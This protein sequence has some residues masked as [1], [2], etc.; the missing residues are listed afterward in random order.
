MGAA[1]DTIVVFTSDH[2][3]MF[4]D[5]GLMLKAMMHYQGA[6]RV[7]LTIAG[8]GVIAGRT[9]S[10]APSLDLAQ[11]FL[12]LTGL[13]EFD[14]M[15]GQSLTPILDDPTATVRDHVFVE[16]DMPITEHAPIPHKARTVFTAE[17]RITRFSAGETE[18]YDFRDDPDELNN[19]A[20]TAPD[21]A[22]ARA[23]SDRLTQ[24]LIDYADMARINP[25]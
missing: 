16:E 15:Q 14:R 12:A 25:D 17:G 20:T 11:T 23:M 5:H 9:D 3:D 1:D 19:L 18:I 22:F 24:T 2:G 13:E 21:T 8:P 4:G 6:L 10:L 7:P